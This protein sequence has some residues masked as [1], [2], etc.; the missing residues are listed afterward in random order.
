MT[1]HLASGDAG[2]TECQEAPECQ[3]VHEAYGQRRGS[4]SIARSSVTLSLGGE[5]KTLTLK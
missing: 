5:Q 3:E 1:P 4:R 2:I